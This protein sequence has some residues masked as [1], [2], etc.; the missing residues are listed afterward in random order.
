MPP[1]E[2][3]DID[4]IKEGALD[5]EA[6]PLVLIN[7]SNFLEA[8][9]KIGHSTELN[10]VT[11]NKITEINKL[12]SEYKIYLSP[13]VLLMIK[14]FC[15]L[16]SALFD[17]GKREISE[18]TALDYA[19]AQK[20]L[21]KISGHGV[22]YGEFIEKLLKKLDEKSMPIS[23]RRLTEIKE[24]GDREGNMQFYNFFTR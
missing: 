24:Y 16:G 15:L 5:N 22:R 4:N 9:S 21:P 3:I 12:L 13:R 18:M 7:G 6:Y 8:L 14:E 10:K 17:E 2:A 11:L 19:V 1:V 20:V 23:F